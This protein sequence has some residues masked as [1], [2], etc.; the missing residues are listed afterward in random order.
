ML[1]V[2]YLWNDWVKKNGV[3]AILVL[4]DWPNFRHPIDFTFSPRLSHQKNYIFVVLICAVYQT[5][6]RNKIDL[7][8]RMFE[9]KKKKSPS[10]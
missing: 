9:K 7:K 10:S 6:I 4:C 1:K 3:N 5:I 8:Q 2:E